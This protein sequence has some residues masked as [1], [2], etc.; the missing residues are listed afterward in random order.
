MSEDDSAHHSS[1][2]GLIA[3]ATAGDLGVPVDA[4]IVPSARYE[5]SLREAARLAAELKCVLL[6]LSSKRSDAQR[7]AD[8]LR[9]VDVD[10]V[11]VDFPTTGI[12]GLPG[13]ET[14][15]ILNKSRLR[16]RT[17]TSAKRNLGLVFARMAGWSR[18]V[19][20]DDDIMVPEADDL[21][22]AVA[23]L[24]TCDA[25]GLRIG[26]YPDNSVVCHANRETGAAQDTFLGGGAMAVATHRIDSFFPEIYNEDWFFLIDDTTL[27]PVG[28]VG[29][30]LQKA[31][32]PFA[33]PDRA[34][35]EEFGDVLAEGLFALFDDGGKIGDA[36]EQY[37]EKFLAARLELITRIK[38]KCTTSARDQQIR[39]SL[40]AAGGR[41]RIITPRDCVVYI[42]AWQRDRTVWATFMTGTDPVGDI[43]LVLKQ[44]GLTRR[45]PRPP[46][47]KPGAR[48]P[49]RVGAR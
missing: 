30:A 44:L 17:D 5:V 38:D 1:H 18:V 7:V 36:T 15:T 8:F 46:A 31:Y 35:D 12:A 29:V 25:V 43:P 23:L 11:P 16:R 26:G 41:L 2:R 39:A 22:R 6:V 9:D 4:I 48:R 21:R 40:T 34:R 13:L 27:R 45:H 3:P 47:P 42:R 37:W 33:N 19:F 24:D 49:E 20:L 28:Q 14:S 10:V 32:D